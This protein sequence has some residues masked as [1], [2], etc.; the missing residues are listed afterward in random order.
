MRVKLLCIVIGFVFGWMDVVMADIASPLA[1]NM[2]SSMTRHADEPSNLLVIVIAASSSD[3]EW[4]RGPPRAR[5]HVQRG[6]WRMIARE[7]RR[8]GVHVYLVGQNST[9]TLQ[10][11]ITPHEIIH[12]GKPTF[13]PGILSATVDSI[14]EVFTQRLPG[15]NAPYVLRSNLSSF[16]VFKKM[17]EW[18]RGLPTSNYFGGWECKLD[19]VFPHGSGYLMSRDVAVKFAADGKDGILK[20]NIPDDVSV[21]YFLQA[22]NL[23]I[24]PMNRT[25]FQ[26]LTKLPDLALDDHFAYRVRHDDAIGLQDIALYTMLYFHHYGPPTYF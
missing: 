6:F 9:V 4:R 7:V 2:V 23:T 11:R 16:W 3:D 25:D 17:I 24:Q 13:K 20:Y 26:L 8:I 10:P 19:V 21:G 5:Q 18:L 1:G 14:H 22:H 15:H 12:P